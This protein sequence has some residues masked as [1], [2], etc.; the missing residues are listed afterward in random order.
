MQVWPNT[1]PGRIALGVFAFFLLMLALTVILYGR[2]NYPPTGFT[3][4][5]GYITA[6]S[7]LVTLVLSLAAV[8]LNEERSIAVIICM[9]TSFIVIAALVIDIINAGM[10]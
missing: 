2:L 5:V 6:I 9:I 7:C 4:V 8:I 1:R 10:A 3:G